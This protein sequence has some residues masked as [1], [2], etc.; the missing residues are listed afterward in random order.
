[1]FSN[2]GGQGV[3]HITFTLLNASTEMK[4]FTKEDQNMDYTV[5]IKYIQN[6]RTEL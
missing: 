1:M 5:K 3:G 4:S 2:G 6:N